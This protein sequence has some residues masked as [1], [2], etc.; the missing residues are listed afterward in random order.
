MPVDLRINLLGGCEV[1]TRNG[2]DLTPR[3]RKARA[4]LVM[5][6]LSPEGAV[7][8]EKVAG[9]LWSNKSDE[10]ARANLRQCLRE[11]RG[12]LNNGVDGIAIDGR[13][14]ALNLEHVS[15]DVREIVAFGERA[16]DAPDD[17]PDLYKGR[18]LDCD[19]PDDTAFDEWLYAERMNWDNR[20][21]IAFAAI[22]Q[23]Q[24]ANGQWPRAQRT[25]VALLRVDPAHEEAHC[26][27]MQSFVSGGDFGS[28]VR[29]YRTL[30][31]VL[32][33]EYGT[34]PSS[35]AEEI[36]AKAR[37]AQ[38]DH[39]TAPLDA[40]AATAI[41]GIDTAVRQQPTGLQGGRAIPITVLPFQEEDHGNGRPGA[42]LGSG[43][44][45]AIVIALSRF[46]S[47][48][49]VS[50]GTASGVHGDLATLP[51]QE[52]AR[53]FKVHYYVRGRVRSSGERIRITVELVNC[54]GGQIVWADR[55]DGTMGNVFDFEDEV[56]SQ[57]VGR[58]DP[59]VVWSESEKVT[60]YRPQN[61]AAYEHVLLA[62][63]SIY[64]SD[65]VKFHEAG[66][67]LLKAIELDPNYSD[68]YA[69]R[70]FWCMHC[71]GQGWNREPRVTLTDA[72]D[73]A[74]FAIALDPGNALALAL[75]G[76]VESF[77]Y[78]RLD[79]GGRLLARALA[80]NPNSSFAWA[81]SAVLECYLGHPEQALDNMA[82]YQ[83]LCPF[84]PAGCYFRAIYVIAYTMMHEFER[85][86]EIGTEVVRENPN[87][88]NSY[89]PLIT[90][91][92]HLG[93][94]SEARS[95]AATLLALEPDFSIEKFRRVYPFRRPAD[96]ALYVTAYRAVGIPETAEGNS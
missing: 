64:R 61:L 88:I 52:I 9:T 16:E 37:T 4:A 7:S 90:S 44:S 92:W 18:L 35:T 58:I 46:R 6:A 51:P 78:R 79:N 85:A 84:D 81:M 48:V 26:A 62:I 3:S 25:A 49:V 28:A 22:L 74:H 43:I 21:R 32:Q 30:K 93:A 82:R 14:I 69:W 83:R 55:F 96:V 24:I 34:V 8:R 54:E 77:L 87:F 13:R 40:P 1:R 41:Q 65:P 50:S 11:L 91:L 76:H 60:R 95:F 33:R 89:K 29:Q 71:I 80:I 45:E 17:V 66:T 57:I 63:P 20:I 12:V 94:E 31:E 5:M 67:S 36:Y 2:E 23:A 75:A 59:C 70:A 73:N 15:V 38:A 86:I 53:L 27:L 10:Q 39:A 56:A 72:A 68:A 47:L 19:L 42:S